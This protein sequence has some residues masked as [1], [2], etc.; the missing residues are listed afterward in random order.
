[1]TKYIFSVLKKIISS[2][3]K[4]GGKI[5]SKLNLKR[6]TTHFALIMKNMQNYDLL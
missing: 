6:H 2:S 4:F 3:H 5:I 1:M